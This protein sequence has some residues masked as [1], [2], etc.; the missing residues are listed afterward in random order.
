MEISVMLGAVA[1]VGALLTLWWALSG[2]RHAN[3]TLDLGRVDPAGHDLRAATLQHGIGPRAAPAAARAPRSLGPEVHAPRSRRRPGAAPAAG[4][5]AARLD[6]RTGARGQAPAR[7]GRRGAR[8]PPAH[9]LA[10]PD[11]GRGRRGVDP[12][13]LLRSGPRPQAQGRGAPAGD[14]AVARRHGRPDGDLGAGRPRPRRRHRPGGPDDRGSAGL[15]ARPRRAGHPCRRPAQ[16]GARRAGRAGP[17]ARAAPDGQRPRPGREAR[18]AGRPDPADPGR[19]AA[20]Q[21]APARRGA[22]DEA[23]RQD[24]VPDGALHPAV[25]VHRRARTRRDQHH[26]DAWAADDVQRCSRSRPRASAGPL[27]ARRARRPAPAHGATSRA[28]GGAHRVR[29]P[30]RGARWR[31]PPRR[32]RAARRQARRRQDDRL[33]PVRRGR[34]P[35]RASS[36]STSATSTTTSRC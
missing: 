16:R 18:R 9:R 31:D 26:E 32:G 24:P 35:N 7:W 10:Q 8:S 30:R 2:A 28:C 4:R 33:P 23:P 11:D 3:A 19:R 29:P 21:A 1:V 27:G 5:D 20:P 12:V 36:S 14:P 15:R 13:R 25:P 22:G 17:R 6:D 34:W